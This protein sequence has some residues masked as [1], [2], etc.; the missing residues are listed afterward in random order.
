MSKARVTDPASADTPG[1]GA[2]LDLAP[3]DEGKRLSAEE[4]A[5]ARFREPYIY[6]RVRGRLVVMSPAGPKH[7]KASRPFR[8]EL[9]LYWGLHPQAIDDVDVE[10]WVATSPDD[11]R[12]PD[13]C[14]YLA[15]SSAMDVPQRVPDIIFEFVSAEPADR[16]RDCF[17]KGAV[18]KRAEYHAVGVKEYVI[19][20]RFQRSV[21]VLTCQ[22]RDF[23][24]RH[25]GRN[26][27][28]TTPLLPGLSVSL[29]EVLE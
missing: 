12:I 7:R 1:A 8:R 26:D 29:R 16:E 21:L 17:S 19:V 22:E 28:Y 10:G 3:E 11:D 18:S 25:L 27:S 20:D 15:G 9:G 14:V 5:R 13:I 24:E 2:V 23:S 4:F 6:E